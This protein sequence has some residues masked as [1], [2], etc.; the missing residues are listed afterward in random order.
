MVF[1]LILRAKSFTDTFDVTI[2]GDTELEGNETLAFQLLDPPAE[3][4]LYNPKTVITIVNNDDTVFPLLV[5]SE[6]ATTHDESTIVGVYPNPVADV[7]HIALARGYHYEVSL[8]TLA[9]ESILH[10]TNPMVLDVGA[11]APAVYLLS[12]SVDGHTIVRR[13]VKK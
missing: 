9:G 13:V 8:V 12:V 11:L 6:H 10:Q 4:I 1:S 3:V 5:N 2:L 7:L